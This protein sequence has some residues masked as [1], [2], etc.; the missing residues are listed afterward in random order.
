VHSGSGIRIKVPNGP[1]LTKNAGAGHF[2]IEDV[3]KI[4]A[5]G[6][7]AVVDMHEQTAFRLTA[8]SLAE[9]WREIAV[10]L[11]IWDLI[12]HGGSPAAA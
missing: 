8:F 1:T 6:L 4:P 5:G 9:L 7:A 2:I 12:R 10:Y 11:E 3:F